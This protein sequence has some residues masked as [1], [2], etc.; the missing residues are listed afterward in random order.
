MGSDSLAFPRYRWSAALEPRLQEAQLR[1]ASLRDKHLPPEAL[2]SLQRWFRIEH[3]YHS[4][5]IEG[6]SLT[7]Q[8]TKL[9]VEDGLTVGGKPLRDH[10]E[11]VGVA[12]AVD[13][14]RQLASGQERLVERHV[15]EIHNIVFRGVLPEE[16]GRYRRVP[17]RI[18]GTQYLPPEPLRLTGLMQTFGRWLEEEE[19]EKPVIRAAAIA[20]DGLA[21]IHPFLDGNGRAARLVANLL[22]MRGHYPITVL[23]VEDRLRYY[24][25]LEA[26]HSG[27]LDPMVA[28]TLDG[29]SAS[30]GEYE[31]AQ[32]TG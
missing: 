2:E 26:S 28:L 32:A 16:A 5:A 9:V 7:L 31:R 24:Q 3:I 21:A 22:L 17:V 23:R 1:V 8:E 15:K 4:N 29:V 6:N 27:D 19:P 30:L 10:A 14:V 18:T 12:H 11:A 20:H 25:A 13:Y